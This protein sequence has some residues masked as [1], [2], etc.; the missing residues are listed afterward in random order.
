MQDLKNLK[1]LLPN[2]QKLLLKIVDEC[3]FLQKYVLVTIMIYIFCSK[4]G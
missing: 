2:T 1:C 3:A 4:R